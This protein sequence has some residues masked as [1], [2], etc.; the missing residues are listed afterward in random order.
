MTRKKKRPAGLQPSLET[1][2]VQKNWRGRT[3]V[4][5][6]YPNRYTAGMANLGFQQVYRI[7][8]ASDAY[9]C[10]RVFLPEPGAPLQ[11][12]ESGRALSDFQIL[13]FSLSFEND[14]L[15]ILKIL[16]AGGIPFAAGDRGGHHPL[17][18]AGGVACML[19][20]EP[21]APFFDCFLIGE[22]EVLLPEFLAAYQSERGRPELL[23]HLSNEV[24]GMY[25][26]ALYGA[27]YHEDGTLAAMLPVDDAVPPRISRVY[28]AE[29]SREATS[30][31]VLPGK[32]AFSS[33]YLVEVSRGC[34]HGC[35][36]CGAGFVYRPPRFRPRS[37]LTDCLAEAARSSGQVGL[38]GAAVSDLPEIDRL[39]RSAAKEGLRLSFSSLRADCLSE[40]LIAALRESRVKT[41]T[42]APD[43]GSPRMRGVINKGLSESQ[44]LDA[45]RRLV[46]GG[47]PN[48]KLYFMVGLPTETMADIDE[49]VS[50]CLRVKEVFLD[51]S[52]PK[53]RI[54]EMTVSLSS[55]VPKPSTPFQWAAMDEVSVLKKKLKR[56]QQGL[57]A[58]ANVRVHADRPGQAHV[59]AILSRGDR[60]VAALLM[61]VHENRGNWPQTLKAFKPGGDFYATRTRREDELFPWDIIDHKVEKAYLW[62]EYRRALA[63]ELTPACP[64]DGGCV[65]CGVCGGVKRVP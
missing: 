13:A 32:T 36:F 49:I 65:R 45:A 24:P 23:R 39:C 11:S 21:V 30:T 60:R 29:L 59:Q 34:P 26:P 16:D 51:A 27:R 57:K 28:L 64:S 38:V 22:A 42:I 35:R 15:N 41:A 33:D 37:L 55:F 7:V 46:I 10:E 17:V 61:A 14:F 47:I 2:A 44:I 52:R 25:V 63:A 62:R 54:G 20:P 5:L 43:A 50:L 1:G 3:P 9:V 40:E 53:G 4:A 12:V 48:L 8:N 58:V 56:V 31:C 6:I 19:N 18:M